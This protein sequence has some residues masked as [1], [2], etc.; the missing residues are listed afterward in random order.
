MANIFWLSIFVVHIGATQRIW[1][2]H[3]CVAAL[4]LLLWP[5]VVTSG[6]SNKAIAWWLHLVSEEHISTFCVFLMYAAASGCTSAWIWKTSV[7]WKTQNEY[8]RKLKILWSVGYWVRL[9]PPELA[10]LSSSWFI[11]VIC[12]T[13]DWLKCNLVTFSDRPNNCRWHN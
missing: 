2:N 4:A 1:L 12:Q 3:L 7:W 5:L 6:Q 11:I 8:W 9:M 13:V 10:L